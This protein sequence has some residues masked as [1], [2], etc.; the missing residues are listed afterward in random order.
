M[1]YCLFW[2]RFWQRFFQCLSLTITEM[3]RGQPGCRLINPC[4]SNLFKY[5]CTVE[6]LLSPTACPISRT[7]GGYVCGLFKNFKISLSFDMSSFLR[8]T[9]VGIFIIFQYIVIFCNNNWNRFPLGN[10]ILD[11]LF[12]LTRNI[13]ILFQKL[14][15]IF[16]ALS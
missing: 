10:F 11:G 16:P 6:L 7:V 14:F 15:N 3:Q 4:S 9:I 13:D 8:Q 12:N 5:T 2:Q 1:Y